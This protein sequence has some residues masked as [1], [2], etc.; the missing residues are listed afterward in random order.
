MHILLVDDDET[1]RRGLAHFLKIAMHEVSEAHDGEAAWALLSRVM[2]DLVLTDVKMPRMSGLDLLDAIRRECLPLSVMVMTAFAT[3]EDAVEAM[4]RGAVDYLTK[5]VNLK[6]LSLKIS[7]IERDRVLVEENRRLKTLLAQWED[8]ELVGDS[9]LMV[10]LR[11]MLGRVA[12]DDSVP[13]VIQ[14]ES[15]TGKELAA[16]MLHRQ[17]PRHQGP[18]VPVNCAALPETLIESELFGYKKGAFTGAL[19]DRAGYFESA[20]GGTLFL[21]ELGELPLTMQAKLLRV[22]QEKQVQRLGD[23]QPVGVDVRVVAAS[24]RP[25]REMMA[26]GTFR[27]DL[28][29]RLAVMEVQMPPL[30]DRLEDLPLLVRRLN[31]QG[32]AQLHFTPEAMQALMQYAWPGNVRELANLLK[33]LG[34]TVVSRAVTPADLPDYFGASHPGQSTGEGQWPLSPPYH[35]AVQSVSHQFDRIYLAHHLMLHSGNISKTATSI[36]L[37][38]AALHR[39]MKMYGMKTAF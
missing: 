30:R 32:M 21:D 24:N 37:S 28:Y 12:V 2:P 8:E 38:R 5:P 13:V 14:G 9:G 18:F 10:S 7:R 27:E 39:K 19:K 25:L 36:G 16:R 22:L 6:A 23:P 31:A 15:G 11:R 33:R 3:V 34:V 35:D 17:S 1:I 29:Y 26:A 20:D 4:Q